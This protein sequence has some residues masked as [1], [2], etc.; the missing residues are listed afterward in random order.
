MKDK[1]ILVVDDDLAF[2]EML[3]E[4]LSSYGAN[5]LIEHDGESG[6]NRALKD[7]PDVIL[8]DMMMP[9]MTGIAA[10]EI[11]RNDKWGKKVP[12]I[13]LT[14]VNQPEAMAATVEKGAPTEYLLKIDWTLDQIAERVKK[15]L[16]RE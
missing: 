7:H 10:L 12:T 15:L 1:K 11:L 13:L 9:K 4:V 5:V 6:V 14:N 3:T 16:D 2:C 8:F